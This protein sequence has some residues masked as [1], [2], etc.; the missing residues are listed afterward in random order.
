MKTVKQYR[1]RANFLRKLAGEARLEA[2]RD[3]YLNL[4]LDWDHMA[5]MAEDIVVGPAG[6]SR[7]AG[8]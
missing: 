6:K 1:E 2:L 5:D 7:A 3:S 8:T 4:A